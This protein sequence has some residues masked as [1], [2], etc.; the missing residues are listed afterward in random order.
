MAKIFWVED[1]F[2]WINK[3]KPL[4]EQADFEDSHSEA[5]DSAV[6]HSDKA[7]NKNQI[8]VHKFIESAFQSV[9]Q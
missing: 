6:S 1:Q 8:E 4:L 7:L 5:P 9:N 2:H 3:F